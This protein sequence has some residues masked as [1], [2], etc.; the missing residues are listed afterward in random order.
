MLSN[1]AFA[2]NAVVPILTLTVLGYTI[3]R[4]G[5]FTDEILKPLNTFVFRYGLSV[6]MF[7]NV[8]SLD[9]IDDI[10]LDLMAYTLV[11]ISLITLLYIPLSAY[12]T[13]RRNRR[14]VMVQTGFRSNYAVIGAALASALC[15]TEGQRL[16]TE[17]QAPSIIFFNAAAVLL[18]TI[19]S[20]SDNRR[21]DVRAIF[22]QIIHNP[23]IIGLSSGVVCLV[24]REFIPRRMDGTLVFSLS[25][26][27]PFLY[28][29]LN[30]LAQMATPLVLIVMGAQFN[31][32]AVGTMKKEI[33]AG[34][35]LRLV[36]TPIL[37]FAMALGAQCIGW[38]QLRPAVVATLLALYASPVAV[39]GAAMAESMNCDGELARQHVV[40]TSAVSM[41]TLFL[42]IVLFRSIGWL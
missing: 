2:F 28:A 24:L 29:P 20:D 26:T 40:W 36:V 18:L 4:S 11:S 32:R 27:L 31:F 9:S 6:L 30:S 10:P 19:Y 14:G 25:G 21:V 41:I 34:V 22:R 13:D 35:L 37:G 3:K 16:S 12:L 39:A 42:R 17:I 15:G 38:I 7:C 8:Y 5:L 1:F 33:V 23:L